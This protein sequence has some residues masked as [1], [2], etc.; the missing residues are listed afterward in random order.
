MFYVVRLLLCGLVFCIQTHECLLCSTWAITRSLKRWFFAAKYISRLRFRRRGHNGAS[1]I[2]AVYWLLC[3][4]EI[5]IL[6]LLLLFC[7]QPCHVEGELYDAYFMQSVLANILPGVEFF[8]RGRSIPTDGSGRLL[9]TN[10]SLYTKQTSNSDEEALICRSNRHVQELNTSPTTNKWYLDPEVVTTTNT[11]TGEM[12]SEEI[13]GKGWT[14]DRGWT[15]NRD[16]VHVNGEGS[17]NHRV[18]RLKRVSETALEGKFTCHITN[19]SNN[20]KSLLILYPSE[21]SVLIYPCQ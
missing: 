1:K 2:E 12:I 9:I 6:S 5:P 15:V 19:D 10:I 18:V 14:D 17:P 3:V 7:L 16:R 11:V 21:F 4:M 13:I 8:L 20:N